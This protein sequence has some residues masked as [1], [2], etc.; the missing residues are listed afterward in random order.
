MDACHSTHVER[1][2]CLLRNISS[3]NF[4]GTV[5]SAIDSEPFTSIAAVKHGGANNA[6]FAFT[7][8]QGVLRCPRFFFFF[9]ANVW[10]EQ[11]RNLSVCQYY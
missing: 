8:S 7:T 6:V 5:C 10:C 1:M 4:I 3:A 9:S 11:V 2:H